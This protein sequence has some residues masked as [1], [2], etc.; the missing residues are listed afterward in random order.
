MSLILTDVLSHTV[1]KT[2]RELAQEM[3][4]TP[5]DVEQMVE[6][7]R[8]SGSLPIM[9]GPDGYRL[10]RNPEEY[11]HNVDLRRKRA[12][13]QLVTVRGERDLLSRWRERLNPSPRPT[14]V[15]KQESL[16][17]S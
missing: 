14:P 4:V 5:R 7:A 15:V 2:K 12:L 11:E 13:V 3:R 17:W 16:P 8:K 9:S 1:Y 6:R 10:A